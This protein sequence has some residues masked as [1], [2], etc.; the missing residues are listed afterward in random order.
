M[1]DFASM[2]PESYWPL[3]AQIESSG[4][5]YAKAPL[6]SGSGLYQ[7]LRSTWIGEGGSWGPNVSK[8]FGGLTPSPAEQTSRAKTF[9]AKN[10]AVLVGKGIPINNASLYAAHFLGAGMAAM[11]LRAPP[12]ARADLIAGTSATN[13]NPSVL[14]GKTVQDFIKWLH[15]K[16][17]AWAK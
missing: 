1:T 2:I 12:E 3:L 6:S 15:D 5:P 9:T 10:V 11:I 16:T 14:K 4:R 13:A 17:G 7:F 8:A